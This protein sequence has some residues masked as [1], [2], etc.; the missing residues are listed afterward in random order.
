MDGLVNQRRQSFVHRTRL[1]EIRRY[2][3]NVCPADRERS[4]SYDSYGQSSRRSQVAWATTDRDRSLLNTSTFPFYPVTDTSIRAFN[5]IKGIIDVDHP[6]KIF[7]SFSSE[8]AWTYG[9]QSWEIRKSYLYRISCDLRLEFRRLLAVNFIFDNVVK[10]RA[11][12]VTQRIITHVWIYIHRIRAFIRFIVRS[13]LSMHIQST[14]RRWAVLAGFT[15]VCVANLRLGKHCN[16]CS[17]PFFPAAL[18]F[19]FLQFVWCVND[20]HNK[21]D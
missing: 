7:W 3:S 16:R 18:F 12:A 19:F 14:K 8:R 5:P 4:A 2:Q 21:H 17:L 11:C 13:S 10:I 15:V 6:W 20:K 1:I 9:R